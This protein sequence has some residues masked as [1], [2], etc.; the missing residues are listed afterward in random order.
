MDCTR[1]EVNPNL[2]VFE[3]QNRSLNIG[4]KEN[5]K[6]KRFNILLTYQFKLDKNLLYYDFS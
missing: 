5:L 6:Y 1:K 3:D 2:H 4:Q